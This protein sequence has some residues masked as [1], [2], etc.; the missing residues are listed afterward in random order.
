MGAWLN[1]RPAKMVMRPRWFLAVD[2]YQ[3]L[4]PRDWTLD[5]LATETFAEETYRRRP[6]SSRG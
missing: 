1:P 4:L 3:T 5:D 6:D 2:S